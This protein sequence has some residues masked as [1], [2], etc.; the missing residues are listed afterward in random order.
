MIDP[1]QICRSDGGCH[2][3]EQVWGA[4]RAGDQSPKRNDPAA[5]HYQI[6]VRGGGVDFRVAVDALQQQPSLS[7]YT[8]PMR[9]FVTRC[10]RG[11]P[12]CRR[13]YFLAAE[14]PGGLALDFIR[15]NLFDRQAMGLVPIRRRGRQ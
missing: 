8:S 13:G 11:C 15:A 6:H 10:W 3:P 2:A 9:R 5:P 14:P 7:C 12:A 1:L 4:G